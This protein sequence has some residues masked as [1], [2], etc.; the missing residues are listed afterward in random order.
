MKSIRFEIRSVEKSE[1]IRKTLASK[2]AER[3]QE[4]NG[5][6][7]E[8]RTPLYLYIPLHR[9]FIESS[10]EKYKGCICVN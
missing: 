4:K 10:A 5:T 2:G 8:N 1:I 3:F 9:V 7:F 6:D